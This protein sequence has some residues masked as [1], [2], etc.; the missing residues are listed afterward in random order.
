[1]SGGDQGGET[2]GLQPSGLAAAIAG[3]IA[4]HASAQEEVERTR[5]ALTDAESELR[6][7]ERAIDPRVTHVFVPN[8]GVEPFHALYY[9]HYFWHDDEGEPKLVRTDNITAEHPFVSG[10]GSVTLDYSSQKL[11]ATKRGGRSFHDWSFSQAGCHAWYEFNVPFSR[12]GDLAILETPSNTSS[13]HLLMQ[14][15]RTLPSY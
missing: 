5:S 3:N 11:T 2:V 14:A 8:P 7:F 1:M 4:L 6:K 15:V 9:E 13:D 10:C 12:L